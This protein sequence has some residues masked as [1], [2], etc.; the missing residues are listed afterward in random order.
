MGEEREDEGRKRKTQLPAFTC[1]KSAL[2]DQR[3][4]CDIANKLVTSSRDGRGSPI[5][6]PAG[7]LK[8]HCAHH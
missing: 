1:L 8:L 7:G 4:S 5:V 3:T 6:Y 2:L